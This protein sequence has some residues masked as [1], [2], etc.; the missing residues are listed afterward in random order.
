M[1]DVSTDLK[2]MITICEATQGDLRSSINTLQ[3]LQ[4]KSQAQMNENI[5]SLK[6]GSKDISQGWHHICEVI[7]RKGAPSKNSK[8]EKAKAD[9]L[10]YINSLCELISRF[11]DQ[12]LIIQ[13][14]FHIYLSML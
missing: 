14:I 12:D 10:P 5:K 2:T 13:G 9:E 3:F 8:V 11:G 1:Q 7:F 6:V 4:Q